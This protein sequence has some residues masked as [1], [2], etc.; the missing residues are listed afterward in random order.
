MTFK[1]ESFFPSPPILIT[2]VHRSG[3]SL[4]ARCLQQLGLFIGSD[5]EKNHESMFFQG[6]SA[7][8]FS[9]VHGGWDAP[10]P[11]RY[12][13]EEERSQDECAAKLEKALQ[14]G[15]LY[16][17][18]GVT[19]GMF[20]F[21]KPAIPQR[22]GWKDPRLM[23]LLP[24]WSKLFPNA[25]WIVIQR[26]GA[27]VAN[28]LLQRE[29]QG[30]HRYLQSFPLSAGY[31]EFISFRCR[32]HDRA[33]SVW[34]E[35]QELYQEYAPLIATQVHEV[36][37]EKLCEEP[38]KELERLAAFAGLDSNLAVIATLADGISEHVATNGSKTE[39][40]NFLL[41]DCPHA[42]RLGYA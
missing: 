38:H 25:K 22:W 32:S 33:Y 15:S 37:Y 28:S 30:E 36:F 31:E 17:E 18:Y 27:D 8:V 35:Y 42:K 7:W 29:L 16:R 40:D 34:Q 5:L 13:F 12:L 10:M 23:V 4:V 11:L 21:G 1:A 19:S 14:H 41:R 24:I 3:T 39:S 9:L 20:S 2:G 26:N 6:L